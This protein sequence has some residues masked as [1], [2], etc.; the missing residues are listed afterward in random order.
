MATAV[1][2]SHSHVCSQGAGSRVS[3]EATEWQRR[4]AANRKELLDLAA[5]LPTRIVT[6]MGQR[7]RVDADPLGVSTLVVDGP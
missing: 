2:T 7:V 5:S 3:P 1:Y 4:M 6:R